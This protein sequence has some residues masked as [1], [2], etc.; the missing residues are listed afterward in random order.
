MCT[1]YVQDPRHQSSIRSPGARLTDDCELPC[2]CWELNQGPV[3]DHPVLL[4]AEPF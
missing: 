3:E 2:G 4:T 1:S